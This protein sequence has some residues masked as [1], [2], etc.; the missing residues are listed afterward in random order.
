MKMNNNRELLTSYEK[1]RN[2]L[3][4]TKTKVIDFLKKGWYYKSYEKSWWIELK[5]IKWTNVIAVCGKWEGPSFYIDKDYL[6]NWKIILS[7]WWI[8]SFSVIDWKEGD[9]MS[10][11]LAMIEAWYIEK[12]VWDKRKLFPIKK[13]IINK[14]LN[15]KE[16][17]L[18]EPLDPFSKEF[19]E[20]RMKIRF[21]AMI[22][23]K[24]DIILKNK[25][26]NLDLLELAIKSGAI[27][28]EDLIFMKYRKLIDD[29]EF[30]K[31]SKMVL[32]R[33][34]KLIFDKKLDE[35]TK[36]YKFTADELKR[37]VKKVID[38]DIRVLSPREK[39]I[40]WWWIYLPNIDFYLNIN[41]I[42][43]DI[44]QDL[45]LWLV[46][47]GKVDK[48]TLEKYYKEWKIQENY[49]LEAKRY[50]DKNWTK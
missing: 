37:I 3:E 34:K 4:Q 49:Y 12:K 7:L 2:Y 32:K 47:A 40:Y 38:Q 21:Y 23:W 13:I 31:Y 42:N 18:W 36:W 44:Y 17:I 27:K 35:Y 20:A 48:K 8:E 43:K 24:L 50:F 28:P 25:R 5:P 30:N 1:E 16:Y 46:Q 29:K 22:L 19:F 26:P 6:K 39:A 45:F 11:W 10:D 14:R 33:M 9:D 41:F 15:E